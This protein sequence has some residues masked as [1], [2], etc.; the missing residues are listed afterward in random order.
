VEQPTKIEIVGH[1]NT[2]YPDAWR[3]REDY[4]QDQRRQHRLY[5]LQA[6]T[7]IV[8]IT[9][10]V[11][12]TVFSYFSAI[13]KQKIIVEVVHRYVNDQSSQE[14]PVKSPLAT[15]TTPVVSLASQQK[16]IKSLGQ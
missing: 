1:V 11:A 5:W 6:A 10:L 14:I 4:L 8:A 15:T 13:E 12:S 3:T 9:G 16:K 2:N 7:L